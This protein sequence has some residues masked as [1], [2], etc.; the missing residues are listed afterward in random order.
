M[1][2]ILEKRHTL[3]QPHSA[4][5]ETVTDRKGSRFHRNVSPRRSAKEKK[6]PRH[7][8]LR[9]RKSLRSLYPPRSNLG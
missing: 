8:A 4:F 3:A 5:D 6:M 7:D 1:A 2:E 9:V